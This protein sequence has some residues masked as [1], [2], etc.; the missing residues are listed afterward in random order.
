PGPYRPPGPLVGPES[1]G[2]PRKDMYGAW[3]YFPDEGE[4]HPLPGGPGARD[5]VEGWYT[6][7]VP[8]HEHIDALLRTEEG[9]RKLAE[10]IAAQ[11]AAAEAAGAPAPE[12]DGEPQ[13]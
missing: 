4:V 13:P 6:S 11:A 5:G 2:W 7:T 3:D 10:A 8:L 12:R 1:V 9:S